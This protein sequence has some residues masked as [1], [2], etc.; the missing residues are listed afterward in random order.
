MS[1]SDREFPNDK[2]IVDADGEVQ[3]CPDII[4]WGQWIETHHR[5]I[6]STTVGRLWISTVFLG[7]N[8]RFLEKDLPPILW[9]T[10]IFDSQVY[11]FCRS[12]RWW[13][14]GWRWLAR[15]LSRRERL[16]QEIDT[17]MQRYDSRKAALKGHRLGVHLAQEILIGEQAKDDASLPSSAACAKRHN[18]GLATS[19]G[20]WPV[21]VRVVPA[22]RYL[23]NEAQGAGFR[24]SPETGSGPY[25]PGKIDQRHWQGHGDNGEFCKGIEAKAFS[26][27]RRALGFGVPGRILLGPSFAVATHSCIY[28]NGAKID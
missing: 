18:R 21:C 28:P 3:E 22:C 9:E 12:G 25:T 4:E 8:H 13:L 6:A 20:Q 2:F 11:G 16:V 23:R 5:T 14:R 17:W 7:L 19:D 15:H 24:A 1:W 26:E 27:D 10:M